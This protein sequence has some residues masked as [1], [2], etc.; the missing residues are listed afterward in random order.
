MDIECIYIY[1][2]KKTLSDILKPHGIDLKNKTVTDDRARVIMLDSA[3]KTYGEK[4]D[5]T[6]LIK[7]LSR[8]SSTTKRVVSKT[9][10]DV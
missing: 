7:N 9:V 2:L 1:C 8:T 4:E 5:W 3:Q 6:I 10:W